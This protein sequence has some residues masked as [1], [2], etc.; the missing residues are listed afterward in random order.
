MDKPVYCHCGFEIRA[1]S[2]E[3]LIAAIR[4][5]A[6]RRHAMAL[7]PEQAL[8]IAVRQELERGFEQGAPT[9]KRRL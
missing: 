6:R 8:A 2:E 3:E 5:H 9:K 4:R 1:E 7:T